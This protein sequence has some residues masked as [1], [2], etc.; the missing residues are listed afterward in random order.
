VC[1][2]VNF[3]FWLLLIF[4]ASQLLLAKEFQSFPNAKL[5]RVIDGDNFHVDIGHKVLHIRLYFVDCPETS[6]GS[7]SDARRVREQ[8]RYFGL[9][10]AEETLYF[11]N[12]ATKFTKKQLSAPFTVYTAFAS[13]LGRSKTR[14]LYG[15]IETE[16]GNDLGSLLVKNGLCRP[17]GVGRKT[18]KGISRDKMFEKLQDLK[19]EALLRR[20]GVWS[21]SDPDEI[22]R[23]REAQRKEDSELEILQSRLNNK[24]SPENKIDPNTASA[25][26]L[27]SIKGIGP[28]IA[29]RIIDGRPYKNIDDLLKV[30]GI[31]PKTLNKI[32]PYIIIK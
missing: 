18:P 12:Q 19:D 16:N 23:L 24:V 29:H 8:T 21:K 25:Q 5:V 20:V 17:Y 9:K 13:A 1:T 14:R 30:K 26:H 4:C 31:G 6:A 7:K 28:V 3:L 32:S 10:N 11:G 2:K 22:A 27:Q 15:L